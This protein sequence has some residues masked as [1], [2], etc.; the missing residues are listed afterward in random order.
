MKKAATDRVFGFEIL[1]TPFV[2]AHLQLGIFLQGHGA[3][4]NDKQHERAAVYL[5]NAL[6]GWKPPT[7]P[8]QKL[9][10]PEMEEERDAADKIK[11]SQ[12]I[13]VVIGNPP[14][15]GFAGLPVE[16]EAGLVEPYRTTKTAPKPQGQGLNDLYVRFFRVAERC[17]TERGVQHGI[18]CYISNYSWLDGLS[19]TGLRERF[20]EEFDDIWIDSLNGDKY[21]TGKTTPD[22]KPDPSVFSTPQNREGIQVGTAVTLLARRPKHAA[23]ATI[24]FRD[25][26][27]D[28]KREELLQSL[29][30]TQSDTTRQRENDTPPALR[31]G[32]NG[33]CATPLNAENVA[34]AIAKTS[35]KAVEPLGQAQ[36]RLQTTTRVEP[37]N[38]LGLPFRPMVT[39]VNYTTWP[40]LEELFPKSFPGVITARD[41]FVVDIDEHELQK[42]IGMY[43]DPSISHSEMAG[44]CPQAMDDANRFEAKP[45]RDALLKRGLKT[46]QFRKYVYRPFDIR[47]IYWEPD[48]K[49]LNEKRTEYVSQL[50]EQNLWITALQQNRKSYDPPVVS[51]ELCSFH[52]IEQK[53]NFFPML[54]RPVAAKGALFAD[55]DTSRQIDGNNANLSDAGLQYLQGMNG[56]TDHPHLFHHT[57]A[58]LHALSY[59][60]E[61]APALRQ[62]WPRVPLPAERERLLA[63]AELGRQVAALL[64]PETKV[65]GVTSGKLSPALKLIG[66]PTKVGGGNFTDDDYAVTARW[67]IAGKGGITMPAKGRVLSRPFDATERTALIGSRT[68][69]SSDF[70]EKIGSLTTFATDNCDSLSLLGEETCDIFLNDKAHWKNVPRPVWEYT[71]GGYQVLKKWLSYREQTLL[72]RPLTVD[73]V[74]HFRDVI[75]RITAL[76]LLGPTLDANYNSTKANTYA[77][78]RP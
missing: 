14:Y 37:V 52:L 43:F 35:A 29:D 13:L 64:D 19:H 77:W 50:G 54:L 24:H 69:E 30:T 21:K 65:E 8:K 56:I 3:A 10:F 25:F 9:V 73:E 33:L 55:A 59:A 62:D 61:N 49:L 47:W 42:R 75:R 2:V 20:L 74:T 76:L 40:L 63:S 23:P 22:G 41:S 11:Q 32:F 44:I 36:G 12:P 48:T 15:N 6:T 53:A 38:A 39:E 1:P 78:P 27:G 67:G 68:R 17:I 4:F 66:Q 7:G 46:D 16:E 26:W 57:I 18:V 34:A 45:T 51:D 60:T 72:G 5:T 31:R 28:K 70:A 71:L 58:I